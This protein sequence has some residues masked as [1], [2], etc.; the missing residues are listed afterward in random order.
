MIW[1]L[2][3][4]TQVKCWSLLYYSFCLWTTNGVLLHG[5][6]GTWKTSLAQLCVHDA[7]ISFFMWIDFRLLVNVIGKF[8]KYYMKFLIQLH[9]LQLLW[10]NA[11]REWLLKILRRPGW[12]WPGTMLEVWLKH[13]FSLVNLLLVISYST[14]AFTIRRNKMFSLC[15]WNIFSSV[16]KVRKRNILELLVDFF[17]RMLYFLFFSLLLGKR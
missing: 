17:Y 1:F 12:K 6:P 2:F 15:F 7:G 11:H 9:R 10:L 3:H 14:E 8:N 16:E 5:T 13:H 4:I